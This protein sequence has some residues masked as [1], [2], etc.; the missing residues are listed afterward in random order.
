[1]QRRPEAAS[2][3]HQLGV[4]RVH[5]KDLPGAL[6]SLGEAARLEPDY[7]RYSYV[8]AVALNSSG[9]HEQAI[10]MLQ[11]IHARFPEDRL[12][13]YA[14]ATIRRDQGKIESARRWAHKLLALDPQDPQAR[15]LA[16]SLK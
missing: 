3:Y 9:R 6:A 11:D 15:Q 13:L 16:E 14:L 7:L 10:A 5:Q 8:H 2:L 1:M 4:S 12:T